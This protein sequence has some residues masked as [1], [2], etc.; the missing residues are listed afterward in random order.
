MP[1]GIVDFNTQTASMKL[2]C[3]AKKIICSQS[4]VTVVITDSYDTCCQGDQVSE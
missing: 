2:T 4:L 1:K 3:F